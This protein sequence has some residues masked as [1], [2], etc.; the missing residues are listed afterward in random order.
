MPIVTSI[1]VTGSSLALDSVPNPNPLVGNDWV[2]KVPG[3]LRKVFAALRDLLS[4]STLGSLSRMLSDS[5]RS[6]TG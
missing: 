3:S 1:L 6:I 2:T 4:D 5:S